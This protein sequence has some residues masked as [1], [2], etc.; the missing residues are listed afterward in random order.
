MSV[1]IFFF[2]DSLHVCPSQQLFSYMG[3]GFPRLNQYYSTKQRLKCLAQGHNSV[4][5]VRL[6]PDPDLGPNCLTF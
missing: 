2:F 1:P 4:P 5:P 3:M 6:K